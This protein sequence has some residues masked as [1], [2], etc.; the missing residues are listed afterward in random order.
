MEIPPQILTVLISIITS[1]TVTISLYFL[2]KKDDE[3]TRTQKKRDDDKAS[4]DKQLDDI[5]KIAV[6]Y[7]Y[8]DS[9]IFCDSW[10]P[11]TIDLTDERYLRYSVYCNLVFNYFARLSDFCE[12]ELECIEKEHLAMTDWVRMHKKFWLSP[13]NNPNENIDSYSPKFVALINRCLG[14]H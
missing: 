11:E 5:L 6:T 13:L 2:K 3:Q 12:F 9:K 1:T 14:K 7:P 10:N 4:L 8:L